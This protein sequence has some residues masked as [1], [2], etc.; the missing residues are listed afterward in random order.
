MEFWLKRSLTGG[1]NL[2]DYPF[3]HSTN[4]LGAVVPYK[5]LSRREKCLGP[6]LSSFDA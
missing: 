6:R 3:S 4:I 5:A 1:T 2:Y